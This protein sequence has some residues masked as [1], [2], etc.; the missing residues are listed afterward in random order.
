MW[1]L[2]NFKLVSCG[3]MN[4]HVG[5]SVKGHFFSPLFLIPFKVLG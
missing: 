4:M 1:G 5:S 2:T 3:Y